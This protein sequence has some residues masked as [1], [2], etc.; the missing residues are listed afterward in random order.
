MLTFNIKRYYIKSTLTLTKISLHD[1]YIYYKL[2]Y[3]NKGKNKL[4]FVNAY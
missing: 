3:I 2:L 4:I 1:L